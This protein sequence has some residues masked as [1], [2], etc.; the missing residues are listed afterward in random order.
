MAAMVPQRS[1]NSFSKRSTNGPVEEIQVLLM[2]STA[3]FS[4]F[5]DK[6]AEATGIF[7]IGT[8]KL[9]I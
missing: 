6:S 4:S 8:Q 1:A 3:Y 9:N 5:P 7:I 2:A